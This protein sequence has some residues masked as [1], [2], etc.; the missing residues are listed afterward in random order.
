V[1]NLYEHYRDALGDEPLPCAAVDLDALEHN[2]DAL[3]APVRRAGKT[4]RVATKSVRSVELLRRIVARG[5]DAVRG[6]MAY[7][8][9][10]AAFLVEAGFRDVLVAYPTARPRDAALV[11]AAN[12]GDAV[13][14]IV[15]DAPEHLAV[16]SE[17]AAAA[18]ARVPVVVDVDVS[19]RPLGDRLPI[20]ARRSP[21]RVPEAV[22]DF[23]VAVSR[24]PHLAFAGLMAYEAHIAGIPDDNPLA[25]L[26]D[27]PKRALKRLARAPVLAQRAAV[28]RACERRG[29]AVPLFDGG[30]TGSAGWSAE[31]PSLTEIAAGSG[32]L[33][34]HLF[35]GYRGLSLTPAAFFALQVTRRP[36]PGFVTCQGGGFLASGAPAADRLP[37]PW[38]PAGLRL[39]PFE[40][41]GEVQTPLALPAGLELP[42]GAPVIFRHAKAGEL[43]E[44]FAEYLLLRADRIE[45]RAITYRGAGSRW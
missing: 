27:A 2:V 37:I 7:A 32:F 42:L 39:T 22:A 15:A 24:T 36:A 18:G 35:D 28:R 29:L 45:G 1:K 11:A 17:A 23:A 14:A 13:V 9:A 12:R 26:L 43:A 25:P 44:H 10:E 40:G 16:L 5:G 33:D 31:D 38:L 8:P 6:L 21:L 41:A 19:Y 34:S 4:L 3:V 20:G 30:G